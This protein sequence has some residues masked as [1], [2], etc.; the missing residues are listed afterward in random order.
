[1]VGVGLGLLYWGLVAWRG[2]S[3]AGAGLGLEVGA[4][5][6]GGQRAGGRLEDI[7]ADYAL[8]EARV[9]FGQVG[10]FY[11]DRGTTPAEVVA[12]L[13]AGL[14]VAAYL[15]GAAVGSDDLAALRGRMLSAAGRP[16]RPAAGTPR[17][18]T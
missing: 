14:D 3:E 8:S 16:S 11:E 13:L 17:P 12:E 18:A 4:H 6:S 9:P 1:V 5:A 15:R 7:A 10:T 2:R